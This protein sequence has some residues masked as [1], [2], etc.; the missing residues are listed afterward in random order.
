M[1]NLENLDVRKEG[2]AIRNS[3]RFAEEGINV[4]FVKILGPAE[5]RI[6]T[7][8]RGVED[9]TMACGTGVVAASIAFSFYT[10]D[11]S[12]SCSVHAQGGDLE[13]EFHL[14]GDAKF[15]NVK[16]IGPAVEVFSGEVGLD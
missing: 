6:R 12:G 4:N 16:L 2:R 1:D 5:I 3:P 8:E 15:S 11:I 9:E 13:V 7:Y 14:G 10:G